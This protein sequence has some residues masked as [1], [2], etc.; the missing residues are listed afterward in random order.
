MNNYR[1]D[2]D[3]WVSNG[4]L[5]AIQSRKA[6]MTMFAQVRPVVGVTGSQVCGDYSVYIDGQLVTW[7][8]FWHSL[9]ECKRAT[10]QI[11]DRAEVAS[12]VITCSVD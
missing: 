8:Q 9:A 11:T 1:A 3:N 2:S 4:I 5:H 7:Y 6:L 10:Y 12:W